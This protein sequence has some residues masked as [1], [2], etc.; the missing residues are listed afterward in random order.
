M[1]QRYLRVDAFHNERPLYLLHKGV[2]NI[3]RQNKTRQESGNCP[4]ETELNFIPKS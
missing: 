4:E 1:V 2:H 3:E